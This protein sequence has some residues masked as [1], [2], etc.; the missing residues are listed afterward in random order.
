MKILF[1]YNY[2]YFLV[3][4]VWARRDTPFRWIHKEGDGVGLGQASYYKGRLK[5]L[6]AFNPQVVGQIWQGHYEWRNR[7]QCPDYWSRMGEWQKC[8][9]FEGDIEW[10]C[11]HSANDMPLKVKYVPLDGEITV[12]PDT[13]VLV[14]E[15]AVVVNDQGRQLSAAAMN[16]LLP[17]PHTVTIRGDAKVWLIRKES[18]AVIPAAPPL[19][20]QRSQ[21]PQGEPARLPPGADMRSSL[22]TER[23]FLVANSSWRTRVCSTSHVR[24]AHL[25]SGNRVTVRVRIAGARATLCVKQT[26]DMFEFEY[27]VAVAE[28]E[29]MFASG[30]GQVEKCIHDV[31][32]EGR[33]WG[34]HEYLGAKRG[35]V[36]AKPQLKSRSERFVMPPWVGREVMRE[37]TPD[38]SY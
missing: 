18:T 22:P 20:V 25:A 31:R 17:R 35:L 13:S 14:L 11:L 32:H 5:T 29:K 36:V 34:I 21:P 7:Q 3:Y 1:T 10:W 23:Q 38:L 8:I 15:G 12:S 28:A 2:S 24:E 9:A 16:H 37:I 6:E 19:A 26:H 4:H 30:G 33:S 27:E